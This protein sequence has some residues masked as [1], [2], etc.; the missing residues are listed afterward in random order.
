MAALEIPYTARMED[1]MEGMLVLR[2]RSCGRRR[3]SQRLPLVEHTAVEILSTRNIRGVVNVVESRQASAR[4]GHGITA[5]L[6]DSGLAMFG[7]EGR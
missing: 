6:A 2:L 1:L 3:Y 5:T 7:A 4:S